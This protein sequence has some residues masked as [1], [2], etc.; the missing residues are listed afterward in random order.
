V[1]AVGA[2]SLFCIAIVP[3]LLVGLVF[4]TQEQAL[5]HKAKMVEAK[6]DKLVTPP[7]A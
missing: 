7:A 1:I 2:V 3:D 6:A 5:L 4:G